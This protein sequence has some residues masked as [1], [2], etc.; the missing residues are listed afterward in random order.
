MT[1]IPQSK[2]EVKVVISSNELAGGMFTRMFYMQGH[3]LK[4]F[5]L[6][7]HQRGLTGTDIYTYKVD[8]EGRNATMVREYADFF[9]EPIEEIAS[10]E[11]S[12]LTEEN[13]SSNN[14][15]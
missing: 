5:D 11:Q 10:T 4:Y 2:D 9:K 6:I 12:N 1:I 8:W 7:S 14:S 15:Q 3:G 13:V